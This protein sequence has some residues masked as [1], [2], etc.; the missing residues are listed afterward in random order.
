MLASS[1]A[2]AYGNEVNVRYK[3]SFA[4]TAISACRTVPWQRC[5]HAWDD[6]PLV[7][8]T[9]AAAMQRERHVWLYTDVCTAGPA[10]QWSY[11]MGNACGQQVRFQT[12]RAWPEQG[13]KTAS[14]AQAT[15]EQT[16][17]GNSCHNAHDTN[18]YCLLPREQGLAN[19][20]Y[21]IPK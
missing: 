16:T 4:C 15:T 2:D 6:E 5:T 8:D 18:Q 9:P 21:Q 17:L 1:F 3:V 11:H 19:T 13:T 7:V 14:A 12:R 10:V 20:K